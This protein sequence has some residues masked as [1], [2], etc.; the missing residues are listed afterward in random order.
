MRPHVLKP[1][2]PRA[3]A[4]AAL[5]AAV[6]LSVFARPLQAPIPAQAAPDPDF[7]AVE[8]TALDL[9]ARFGPDRVLLV[10]D[11]DNTLLRMSQDLGSDE[12]Y[13]WQRGLAEADPAKIR[14]LN[15]AQGLLFDLSG[16]RPP[17]PGVQ[18][19]VVA[20]LQDRGF[21]AIVLTG[22]SPAYRDATE[23]ELTRNGY[24]FTRTAVP[25]R[26]GVGG[27]FAPYD[28]RNGEAAGFVLPCDRERG[29]LPAPHPVS[30]QDGVMMTSGQ[31]KGLMLRALLARGGRQYAAVLFVDDSS[32]NLDAIRR[33]FAC[34]AVEVTT[35]LYARGRRSAGID[36][37]AADGAWRKLRGV[38]KEV[39]ARELN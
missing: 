30:Y 28:P 1:S 37:A 16:M 12:W 6:C 2:V 25:P 27:S 26:E 11:C 13:S 5:A 39:F 33:A 29:T 9:G 21:A 24:D 10:F 38:L 32:G 4:A 3:F 36:T 7:A 14:E 19:R 22:R 8:K 17:E 34:T 18:P 15:E 31:D 35:V 20:E 23:R